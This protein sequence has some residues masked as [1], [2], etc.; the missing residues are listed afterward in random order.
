MSP[1]IKESIKELLDKNYT[2]AQIAKELGV[3]VR[4]IF[5]Y[6]RK[7][8]M[9]AHHWFRT[10]ANAEFVPEIKKTIDM[11]DR[12]IME[13]YQSLKEIEVI[14]D[15][16]EEEAKELFSKAEAAQ[17]GSLHYQNEF[18]AKKLDVV[19]QKLSKKNEL[20][21]MIHEFELK[22]GN[23]L[24]KMPMAY[25]IQYVIKKKSLAPEPAAKMKAIEEFDPNKIREEYDKQG[26]S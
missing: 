5:R 24:G 26:E 8:K 1:K 18:F 17:K 14:Y 22:R 15:K 11:L 21:K 25:A 9:E 16:L 2:T 23:L 20:R 7:F 3:N 19:G 12:N 13:C 4:T 10:L 6:K